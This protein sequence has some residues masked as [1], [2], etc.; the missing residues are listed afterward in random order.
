MRLSPNTSPF[1]PLTRK[2]G[3]HHRAKGLHGRPK[4]FTS[5]CNGFA[6]PQPQPQP[7]TLSHLRRKDAIVEVVVVVV[8]LEVGH[9]D[10]SEP[11]D[12]ANQP[13]NNQQ[14]EPRSRKESGRV[15]VRVAGGVRGGELSCLH[16]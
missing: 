2:P 11:L 13:I 15:L 10:V 1:F 12:L 5:G 16:A 7:P 9:L 4:H 3:G 14:H 8:A 6:T